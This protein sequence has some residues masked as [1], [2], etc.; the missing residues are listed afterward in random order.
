MR[1]S[2][3]VLLSLNAE[4]RTLAESLAREAKDG[5]AAA[6]DALMELYW[7][8]VVTLCRR[9]GPIGQ[10]VEHVATEIASAFWLGFSGWQ[11]RSTFHAWARQVA[12]GVVRRYCSRE[13]KRSLGAGAEWD[14]DEASAIAVWPRRLA[15]EPDELSDALREAIDG[16][17]P[18]EREIMQL[19]LS[20]H[21]TKEIA[22]VKGLAPG[23]VR[24]ALNHATGKL[25]R[26]LRE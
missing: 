12:D 15:N 6:F 13:R 9:A 3:S 25:R 19:R 26:A 14:G 24:A 5:D 16:L 8:P 17:P 22:Q 10:D 7:D 21:T 20:G 2:T 4:T 11:G 1:R 23:T 18:Q